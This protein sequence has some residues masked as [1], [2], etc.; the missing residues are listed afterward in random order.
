[1]ARILKRL[2]KAK[3]KDVSVNAEV[4]DHL[5]TSL[6]ADIKAKAISDAR[7]MVQAELDTARAE[8]LRSQ[9]ET[10]TVAAER[11][12]AR[13]LQE[14]A[15]TLAQ[16]LKS[17]VSK[18]KADLRLKTQSLAMSKQETTDGLQVLKSELSQEK[19]KT[20]NFEIQI[21]NLN[22]KLSETKNIKPAPVMA[23]TPIPSF[24]FKPVRGQDGRISSVT[25]IPVGMN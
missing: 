22:G 21:A 4:A 12:A 16:E 1:M 9:A 24:E 14:S 7:M 15:N 17:T 8:I 3:K 20:Q 5:Y 23:P 11:D 10:K 13:T 25:A 19:L 2:E 18:L 6:M